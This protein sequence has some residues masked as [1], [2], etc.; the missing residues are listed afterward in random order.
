[1]YRHLADLI[2]IVHVL[3]ITFVILGLLLTI[4]GGFRH[5]FWVRNLWFRVLH[6]LAIGFVVAQV[7][8]GK[9]CPLTIWEQQ[10]RHAAGQATYRESF[11]EHWL[12]ILCFFHA[13]I[14]TFLWAYTLFRAMVLLMIILIPPQ[15]RR[16]S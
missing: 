3:F 7:W 16:N 6:L 1:M 9:I 11:I 5:W 14:W 8:C 10:L 2:L 13:P 4:L 15:R 12:N